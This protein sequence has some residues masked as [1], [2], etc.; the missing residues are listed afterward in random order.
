MASAAFEHALG[1]AHQTVACGGLAAR[2][3]FDL[4]RRLLEDRLRRL[5]VEQIVLASDD[6]EIVTEYLLVN[7]YFYFFKPNSVPFRTWM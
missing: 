7:C 6:R 5:S 3:E 1:L 4:L 2:L